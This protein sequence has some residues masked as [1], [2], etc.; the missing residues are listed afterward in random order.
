MIRKKTNA[1]IKTQPRRAKTEMKISAKPAK[2]NSID[3]AV[4]ML[5]ELGHAQRE[6]RKVADAVDKRV[7]RLHEAAH[8][9]MSSNIEIME[10][11]FHALKA[12][13]EKYR[14]FLAAESSTIKLPTG[15]LSWRKS[16]PSVEIKPDEKTVLANIEQLGLK[17]QF[18]RIPPPEINKEAMQKDKETA[19]TIPGVS[20][21]QP[22]VFYAKPA[23]TAA[24]IYE[25]TIAALKKG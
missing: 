13:A 25:K 15:N 16:K 23:V 3:D 12:F 17:D 10:R 21:V 14:P 2:C 22:E 19:L 6:V 7:A 4:T 20:F 8:K 11:H 5:A 24:E 1:K 9:R 18:V